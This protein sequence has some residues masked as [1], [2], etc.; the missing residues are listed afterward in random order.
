MSHLNLQD[1]LIAHLI[2]ALASRRTSPSYSTSYYWNERV[3]HLAHELVTTSNSS[4]ATLLQRIIHNATW[5]QRHYRAGLSTLQQVE[6]QEA[7]AA[8]R[9]ELAAIFERD[10]GVRLEVGAMIETQAERQEVEL[11]TLARLRL[12]LQAS[13]WG[14]RSLR[15]GS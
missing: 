7:A 13:A 11:R 5:F 14:G 6:A 10:R 3:L 8:K 2:S 9:K 4:L 12:G 15:F 1:Q